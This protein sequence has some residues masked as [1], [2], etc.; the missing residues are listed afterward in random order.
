IL[1][2]RKR[3]AAP[4]GIDHQRSL[5]AAER[6][7]LAWAVARDERAR[8]L[9]LRDLVLAGLAIGGRIGEMLAVRW[10][11]VQFTDDGKARVTL[12]G[13]VDWVRGVGLQRRPPKTESSVRTL[14]VPRRIAA[15]LRRRARAAGVSLD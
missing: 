6:V 9:D 5:T 1:A 12:S 8:G 13:T 7:S 2:P 14:P 3:K 10:C 4:G 11:D 15:L